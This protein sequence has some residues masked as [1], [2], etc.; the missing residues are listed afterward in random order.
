MNDNLISVIIPC[1]NQGIFL[2]DTL[3]SVYCQTHR[4]IEIIIVD[5]ASDDNFTINKL[6]GLKSKGLKII[7]AEV[8]NPSITRN[9]GIENCKGDFYVPLDADDL[10]H[11]QF[12]EKCLHKILNNKCLGAVS[13]WTMCFGKEDSLLKYKSGGIENYL[14][15]T[16]CTVTALVKK[17]VWSEVK[18]Y[19]SDMTEGMEDWD[20]WLSITSKNYLIEIIQEPLFFYRIKNLSRQ[21][22][23]ITKSEIIKKKINTKH[24]ILMNRYFGNES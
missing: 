11:E 2:Q 18:G 3:D 8:Y 17:S 12:I 20:F 6:H 1:H 4:N 13:S 10:L 21:T 5:D 24:K 23:A 19:D 9:I 16:N 14:Y 22:E 7:N 15:H